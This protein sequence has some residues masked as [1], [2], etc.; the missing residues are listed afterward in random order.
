MGI[1]DRDYYWEKHKEAAKSNVSDFESLLNRKKHRYQKPK[2]SSG[3]LGYLLMPALM[4][5]ALW[6]GADRLY[7][8]RRQSQKPLNQSP[9]AS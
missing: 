8:M 1:Q 9:A 7:R 3:S 5:F 6:N 4:L 2:K